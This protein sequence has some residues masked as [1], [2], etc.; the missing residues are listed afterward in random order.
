LGDMRCCGNLG[1]MLEKGWGTSADIHRAGTMY[2][3]ACLADVAIACRNNGRIS[4]PDGPLPN[5]TKSA[6]SYAR[7]LN[8]ALQSCDRGSAEGCAAAGYMYEDGKGT[9][10]DPER[11]RELVSRACSLGYSWACKPREKD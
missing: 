2:E 9:P 4:E 11:G 8:L 3:R 5:A 6:N 7:A 10:S 1:L